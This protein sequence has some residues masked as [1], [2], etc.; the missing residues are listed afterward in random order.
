[1]WQLQEISQAEWFMN[2]A[3]KCVCDKVYGPVMVMKGLALSFV[4][5]GG[6]GTYIYTI[7]VLRQ[8]RRLKALNMHTKIHK[9]SSK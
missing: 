9:I 4:H 7:I 2:T 8:P 1:M 6:Q 5:L 3:H